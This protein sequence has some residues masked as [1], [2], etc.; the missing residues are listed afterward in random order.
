[1][2]FLSRLSYDVWYRVGRRIVAKI[3]VAMVSDLHAVSEALNLHSVM[4]GQCQA[5]CAPH[6]L[7]PP[8]GSIVLNGH[9]RGAEFSNSLREGQ[10]AG[11][12]VTVTTAAG[13]DPPNK[14]DR[15]RELEARPLNFEAIT[16][17]HHA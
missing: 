13:A 2:P 12:N 4:F 17:W 9:R 5:V 11:R 10:C 7:P 15:C 6:S 3:I 1:M 16:L 8:D 14:C